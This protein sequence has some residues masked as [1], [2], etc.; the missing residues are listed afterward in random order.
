MKRNKGMDM[1]PIEELVVEELLK[2]K[3]SITT[4]ESCT[5]G[6]LAGTIINV[7]GVS[8]IYKEGF[9]TYANEAKEE[10]LGVS[11]ED[12]LTVGAVSEQVA[13]QMAEG[14]K[15][16]A[17]SDCALATT[18]IAGPDGGTK[19]K[20]VGLVYI[21]C[22]VKD[23]TVVEKCLFTGSRLEVRLQAVEK[24]LQILYSKLMDQE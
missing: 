9:I 2:K 14:A 23:K 5:G 12:L 6:L 1:K 20:P 13:R 7:S 3:Y 15:K 21:G 17:N 22:C 24:A 11:H 10:L 16:R 4:A 19:E 18:G 8:S